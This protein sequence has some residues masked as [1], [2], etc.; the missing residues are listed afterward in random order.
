MLSYTITD[1]KKK[2][3]EIVDLKLILSF[4]IID[5]EQTNIQ[6]EKLFQ[7]LVKPSQNL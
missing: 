5:N 3:L 7:S 4:E 6:R 2:L 1:T